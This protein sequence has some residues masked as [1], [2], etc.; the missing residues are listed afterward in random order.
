MSKTVGI[1]RGLLFYEYYPL[2]KTFLEELGAEVIVSD[3]TTKHIMDD[4]CKACV[5]EA[6]LPVKVF[7]GHVMNLAERVDCLLI[8][9]FTSISKREYICPKIGGLPDMVRN[10]LTEL[11][12][13]IDVEINL[14]KSGSNAYRAAYEI[15]MHFNT[16]SSRIKAAYKKA[17]KDHKEYKSKLKKGFLPNEIIDKNLLQKKQNASKM[18][19]VAVIGHPYNLFDSYVS[20]E[21]I[22]KMRKNNINV[23]TVD[24][25]DDAVINEKQ[26]LL[27]K[28]MFWNFGRRAVGSVLHVLDR[29]DIEGIIYVMSFGCGVDSFVCDMVERRVRENSDIPFI[30]IT[31]D[32]H[33]GEAGIDTR[34][35][36]FIDMIRWR[37]TNEGNIPAYG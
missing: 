20:M 2:W 26:A 18:L 1:P 10:T 32:E 3:Q 24:M 19:Q 36:A 34:M 15:G 7:H 14:R 22:S 16:D 31:L 30:V 27:K 21:M 25:V 8:P 35:E 12:P 5:D 29:K 33:S 13:I 17:E 28:K 23:L 4:G 37:K 11:P 9:R 6:C